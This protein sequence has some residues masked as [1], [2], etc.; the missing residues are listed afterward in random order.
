MT[1]H[2]S[3][4]GQQAK[5]RTAPVSLGH[6]RR[7]ELGSSCPAAFCCCASVELARNALNSMQQAAPKAAHW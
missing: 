3:A 5:T 7:W 6:R 1:K 4:D 2:A